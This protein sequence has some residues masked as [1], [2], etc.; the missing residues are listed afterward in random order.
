MISPTT[1]P[2]AI[3]QAIV[4]AAYEEFL[5]RGYQGG[6]INRI[7]ASADA[8][9]GA[10]F[11]HFA[12]KKALGLSVLEEVIIPMVQKQWVE[13]MDAT[14]NPVDGLLACLEEGK[15]DIEDHV[16][17]GCPLGNM[18]QEMS[19]LD[20]D[21]R[22]KIEEGYDRWRLALS[23][24]LSRGQAAGII[25]ADVDPVAVA[26]FVLSALTGMLANA[27]NAQSSALLLSAA[28]GL[29]GYM[30]SLKS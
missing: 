20:E 17:F 12:G 28:N 15:K 23:N 26:A 29:V 24:S 13:P 14:D 16:K 9:K 27:K 6:S 21:F 4:H 10:L 1:A 22:L 18:S 25:R 19:P 7:I 8:T 5:L 11:H 2:T 3:R 30:M